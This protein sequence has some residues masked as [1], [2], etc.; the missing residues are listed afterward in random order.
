MPWCCQ[1]TGGLEKRCAHA[2]YLAGDRG[3]GHPRQA[4]EFCQIDGV[5][6]QTDGI[7]ARILSHLCA[8]L[9]GSG[10]DKLLFKM[11][12]PQQEQLQALVTRRSQLVKCAWQRATALALAHA[13]SAKS[14]RQSSADK[15]IRRFEDIGNRL[16]GS[17][18][19]KSLLPR[20]F[21]HW[22]APR[23]GIDG[24]APE[25][26]TTQPTRDRQ[27]GRVATLNHDS[28]VDARQAL[29]VGRQAD[30]SGGGSCAVRFDRLS[31]RSTNGYASGQAAQG[32]AGG[33][34]AQ[35]SILNAVIK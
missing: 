15:Q 19:R 18:L 1:A 32:C 16:A 7:D 23:P 22:K 34:N 14:S 17:T 12:T 24:R 28:G 5:P 9:H 3:G 10:F 20:R 21:R 31:K 8:H 11:A 33:F 25:L 2:L 29:G 4:H 13:L 30:G 26:G 27:T 35:N 6:G